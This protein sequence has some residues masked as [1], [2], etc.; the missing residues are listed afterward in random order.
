MAFVD[1]DVSLQFVVN[2]KM[3]LNAVSE[4]NMIRSTLFLATAARANMMSA[5]KAPIVVSK[6]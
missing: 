5:N 1:D 6:V 2:V 4:L 3:T